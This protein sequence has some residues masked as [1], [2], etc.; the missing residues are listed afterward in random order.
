VL[1]RGL[2]RTGKLQHLVHGGSVVERVRYR[3]VLEGVNS[4]ASATN[5]QLDVYGYDTRNRQTSVTHKNSSGT[6]ISAETYV[7][8]PASNLTSKTVG[9]T[10]TSFT[11]DNANQLL[12]EKAPSYSESFTYDSNGK[13][14]AATVGG[15]NQTYN[16]DNSDK[17]TSITNGS[18]TLKAYTYDA[19]GRTNSVVTSAGTTSLSYDYES[20]ITGITYPS[21]ATKSFTYNGLDTRVSKVDSGGTSN[22]VREGADVTSPVP[23]D[24]HAA[25]TPA[26]SRRASSATTFDNLN[27]LGTSDLQT[28]ASQTSTY[29]AIGSL[30]ASTGTPVGPFGFVGAQGYQ[31]DGDSG[32]KL[33]GHRRYDPSTGR[34]LTRDSIKSGRNWYSY[35]SNNPLHFIDPTGFLNWARIATDSAIIAGTVVLTSIAVAALPVTAPVIAAIAI[36]AAVGAVGGAGVSANDYSYTHTPETWDPEE[37]NNEVE[38]GAMGGAVGGAVT[39]GFYKP[40]LL[41]NFLKAA[42]V[43]ENFINCRGLTIGT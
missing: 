27:Y 41:R 19:A 22:Y 42:A 6:T 10:T 33:L 17:L 31:E 3:G 8:D 30:V 37:F 18:T 9:S 38:T 16:V 15:V 5:G 21:S 28:N 20:R 35:C 1:C 24:G 7:L 29:D 26:V 36:A 43:Y 14:G 39:G 13:R 23:G 40:C 32:L 34:F 4:D 2:F 12:T 11:Y 25:Y